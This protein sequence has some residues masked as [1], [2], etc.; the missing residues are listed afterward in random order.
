[1]LH[2]GGRRLAERKIDFHPVRD[3]EDLAHMNPQR[4]ALVH[5]QT[6]EQSHDPAA[7]RA[8][9]PFSERRRPD[10][11]RHDAGRRSAAIFDYN[12]IDPAHFPSVSIDYS[13]VEQVANQLHG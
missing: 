5:V 4:L 9:E 10:F 13:F 6:V 12:A 7:E 1:V 3:G 8:V 11:D 2:A